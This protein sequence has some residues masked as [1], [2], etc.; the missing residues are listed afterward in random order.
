MKRVYLKVGE[1]C[2]VEIEDENG[3]I[4]EPRDLIGYSISDANY[5]SN[6]DV[7]LTLVD[8]DDNWT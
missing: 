2:Y 8:E 4:L 6:A 3:D 1:G 5:D 7:E